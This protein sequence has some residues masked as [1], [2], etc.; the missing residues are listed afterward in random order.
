MSRSVMI[1]GFAAAGVAL[2]LGACTT[3]RVATDVNP[4][5]SVANCHTYT[6]ASEH[7]VNAG[8][9]GAWGNPLNADRLRSAIEGNMAA[10]GVSRA[11][12]PA[13]GLRGRLRHR[14]PAGIQRLL[15]RL[16]TGLGRRLGCGLRL[17]A[18]G[19]GGFGGWGYDGPWVED[20]TRIA[21]DIFDARAHKAI[22]HGAVS[23]N[24]S[25]LRGA[26][27]EAKINAAAA[28]IFAKLPIGTPPPPPRAARS[29]A[30]RSVAAARAEASLLPL[31]APS[32][33]KPPGARTGSKARRARR[34]SPA[35][36][37]RIDAVSRAAALDDHPGWRRA[38]PA[39]STRAATPPGS[40]PSTS[41]NPTRARRPE[42]R[43][44]DGSPAATARRTR[45]PSR[46]GRTSVSASS[47][48]DGGSA[49]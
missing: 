12:G 19:Y 25:D 36:A 35:P 44:G 31:R 27:A 16:G 3:L 47:I 33:A 26:N 17:G 20:E 46:N 30:S 6:F 13:R 28:A 11:D 2:A 37:A 49:T 39:P 4:A 14:H 45:P 42:S 32:G 48:F 10:R 23:Q 15:R 40:R 1:R 8:Q 21:I 18:R 9:P 34:P 22:W 7:T 43:S 38:T 5:Y 24:A 41:E 29:R